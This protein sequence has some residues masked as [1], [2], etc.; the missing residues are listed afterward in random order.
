MDDARYTFRLKKEDTEL[1]NYFEKYIDV[2]G[3]TKKSDAIRKILIAG[4][5]PN[6]NDNQELVQEVETLKVMLLTMAN[7]QMEL[8]EEMKAIRSSSTTIETAAPITTTEQT[9]STEIFTDTKQAEEL[10]EN[11]LAMFDAWDDD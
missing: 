5:N 8:L 3:G 9:I 7:T 11:A 2:L 4:I 6:T 1:R 10:A